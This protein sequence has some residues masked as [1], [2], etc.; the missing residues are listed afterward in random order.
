[1]RKAGSIFHSKALLYKIYIFI[2]N[3]KHMYYMY[4]FTIFNQI[5]THILEKKCKHKENDENIRYKIWMKE[6]QKKGKKRAF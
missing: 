1:M 2:I 4:T 6:K 3:V 5:K